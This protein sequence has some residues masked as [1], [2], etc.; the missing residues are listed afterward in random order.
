MS[1][2]PCHQVPDNDVVHLWNIPLAGDS[3]DAEGLD[4]PELLSNA[5]ISRYS[6]ITHATLR[7]RFLRSRVALRNILSG[8]LDIAPEKIEFRNNENGKP[9]LDQAAG[10]PALSFNLSHSADQ[11]LLA[12]TRSMNVGVD[13]EYVRPGRD[14][15]ALA[16]R[17]FTEQ[18]FQ[19][20]ASDAGRDL[21]YRMW[22]LKEA[23]VKARGM[24]LLAGLD[25]FQCSLSGDGI[26]TVC[27]RSNAES[28]RGW[29]YRQWQP[30]SRFVAAVVANTKRAVCVDKKLF[31]AT[32]VRI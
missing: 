8:Y 7:R 18:E 31:P 26:L 13:I 16:R 14:Y 12:V 27:D 15:L 23:S 4:L 22:V 29:Y 17:F 32:S 25:R 10:M 24:K 5:E 19:L 9:F 30:D 21:F 28:E 20:L 6:N 2:K 11:Y 1:D 3:T